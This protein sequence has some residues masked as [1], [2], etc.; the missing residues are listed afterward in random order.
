MNVEESFL[1]DRPAT[2]KELEWA[3]LETPEVCGFS[4]YE[5]IV[6]YDVDSEAS[7]EVKT[8]SRSWYLRMN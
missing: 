2:K 4:K 3:G 1:K 8:K 6:R 7:A 5:D